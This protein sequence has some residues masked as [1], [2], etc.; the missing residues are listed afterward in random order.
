MTRGAIVHACPACF[1]SFYTAGELAVPL[2]LYQPK[3]A[4]WPCPKCSGAME[5][6]TIYEG[7]IELDRC[8]S[9]GGFW[10]DAGEIASLRRLTG[11]EQ[12]VKAPGEAD[13]E[14]PKEKPAAPKPGGGAAPKPK[15]PQPKT[16]S[17]GVDTPVPPEMDRVDLSKR[18]APA[19][20]TLGATRYKHFQTSIPVTT[21]VF[22]E[23]PWIAAVGDQ[24][25]MRDFIHPPYLLSQEKTGKESVWA[26]GEYV[27]P[28]E[29][30]AAFKL[31]GTPPAKLGTAPNQPNP[32]GADIGAILSA[33]FVGAA[34]CVAVFAFKSVTALNKQ[35]LDANWTFSPADPEK[36]RV[37]ETFEVPGAT[38]N[39]ELVL[40]TNVDNQWAGF[41]LALIDA[42]TDRAY[43]IGQ[44][45]SYYH[46]Y[47]DGESWS[48]GSSYERFYLPS[49]PPGRYYLRVEPETD[50]KALSLH[51]TVV[52]D[53]P[54]ERI[55]IIAVLLLLLPAALFWILELN[56]ENARWMDSDHPP[57]TSSD[58]DE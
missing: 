4:E 18:Q 29:I 46:G 1:G 3:P 56:F 44:E 31:P 30:W 15:A 2:D 43:D 27:E 13:A 51:A 10:F 34:L 7:R 58:D 22:G 36:S 35:V 41:D 6:G 12:I 48:E 21:A 54:L 47:E 23:F 52:R 37:S 9:C 38:S 16:T 33:A 42:D 40:A 8:K 45:I 53:V 49:V 17:D 19:S 24:V 28:E 32:W 14:K 26:L 20:V 57:I 55:P 11:I 50:S 5:T 25:E 39:L